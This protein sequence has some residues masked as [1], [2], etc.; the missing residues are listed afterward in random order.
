M[1]KKV[2]MAKLFRDAKDDLMLF[3][4]VFLPVE[5]EVKTPSFQEEWGKILLKG[6]HH[7]AVEGFRESG[8][9]ISIFTPIPTPNGYKLMGEIKPG[10]YV[11]DENGNPVL[12][13]STSEIFYDHP[14]FKVEFDDGEE[15]TADS[16][17]LWSVWDK[18]KRRWNIVTTLEMYAKQD[19]GKPKSGYQEKAYRI[20]LAMPLQF[21]RKKHIISPY[22][23]GLWLGDG[24]SKAAEITCGKE[25]LEDTF[26]NIDWP[27]KTYRE[28]K[29]AITIKFQEGF[30]KELKNLELIYDKHIPEEYYYDSEENR[31]QLLA[32]LI[33]SDGT[34]AKDGSKAGTVTFTNTNER[35]AM[36]TLYLVKSLGIKATIIKKPSKLYDKECKPH[37]DVSFKTTVKFPRLKRKRDLICDT[38]DKRTLMRSVKK[39]SECESVPTMCIK[40]D[41]PTGLFLCGTGCIVTHNSGVVLRTFPM[42]CLTYPSKD[43]QY[44]VFIMATQRA[45]SKRLKEIEDEWLN[46]ELLSMNLVRIVEQ[47]QNGFEVIVKDK[48]DEEMWVRFEAYGK[49]AAIRGLNVHDARPSIVLIDDPQDLEDAKSDTVQEGD[50]EW[51]LS[52]VLFLGKKT[53]IFMIGNNLGEKCL[54]ERVIENQQDLKFTGVRIPILDAE[55]NSVWPE[56]WSSEEIKAEREAFRRIGNLDVWEREKMCIAISPETQLFKKEYF[57]YYKQEE[58]DVKDMNI[59]TTVDLAISQKETADYTVVC[60]VGVNSENHWF[61]LDIRYGRFDPTQTIDAIFE[62]VTRYH[63]VYVGMEK[64]AYQAAL[65]H[66]IEKEMPKRNIWFTVKDLEAKEKKEERIKAIQP[67]FKAGTVWFPMGASF[68]GELESEFLAFPKSLHDDLI[69]AL[70]YQDQIYF[71]PVASYEKVVTDE[72]PLAGSM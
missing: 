24:H 49:G 25:D 15:I 64:V 17:H 37:Y 22:D 4:R 48:D 44:V 63:P 52:D 8:K 32:G 23:L 42:H 56:R 45:A 34:I 71:A 6:K 28:D 36:G 50:W 21:P 57:K 20:P 3:R 60:T 1:D 5:D 68:L 55:G 43:R 70:A 40:V 13:G 2:M 27:T 47:S 38:H 61:V 33:D 58:L 35:L 67:R 69:D 16:E 31:W 62:A 18:H 66:F 39:V 14:C 19:L 65:S 10:D 53:R 12:V 46:N 30:L 9:A 11:F 54:I 29:A 41:S 59:F 26:Q 72:I 51:F 7:Y